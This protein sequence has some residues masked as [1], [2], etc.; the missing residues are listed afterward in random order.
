MPNL[1]TITNYI[2]QNLS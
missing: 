2:A 1:V